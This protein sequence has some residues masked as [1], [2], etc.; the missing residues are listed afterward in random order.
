MTEYKDDLDELGKFSDVWDWYRFSA[1]TI[2]LKF[3]DPENH[4]GRHGNDK[5]GCIKFNGYVLLLSK[6]RTLKAY[7]NDNWLAI[8]KIRSTKISTGGSMYFTRWEASMSNS[9]WAKAI[10]EIQICWWQYLRE[11]YWNSEW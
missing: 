11:E 8:A 3:N 10:K 2:K 6:D 9:R 5:S 1:E 4:K 7:V